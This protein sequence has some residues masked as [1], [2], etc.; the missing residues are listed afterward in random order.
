MLLFYL[1]IEYVYAQDL[2]GVKKCDS[3]NNNKYVSCRIDCATKYKIY[4]E[5]ACNMLCC[6][7]CMDAAILFKNEGCCIAAR[8]SP[9]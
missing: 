7:Y 9:F 3:N 5:N 6:S 1:C 4:T 8:E 2:Y